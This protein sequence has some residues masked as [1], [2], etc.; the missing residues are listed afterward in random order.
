MPYRVLVANRGEIAIRIA[1]TVREMGL[2]PLGIYTKE[3]VYSLHRRFMFEDREVSSYLDIKDIVDVAVEMGADAVHPGYGFLSENPEFAGEV[4]RKGLVFV[5]PSPQI[6]GMAGDKTAAKV[7]AEKM[8]IPTLPWTEA[9]KLEDVVEFA[10]VHG[11]PVIIKAAGGGGGRGSRVVW[12]EK[13]V[14]TAFEVARKEA[15]RA[16]KD[17]RLF[18]EPYI[19]KAKHIEVQVIGDGSTVVHLFERECSIQRRFQ[20]IVEEAPSPSLNPDERG[21]VHEY[22]VALASGLRYVNAGTVEFVFDVDRREFYFMEINTRIQ[23]EHPVTEMITGIDIVKKQIE[24]ALYG[25]LDLRQSDITRRGHAIEVRIYAEN[26]LTGE[27]SP[28]RITRYV[29]PVG[30]GVRVDTGVTEGSIVTDR[31][32]PLIS[33][34]IVWGP[35]RF[36]ALRRLE[37]ALSE[38][39]IEGVSTNIKQLKLMIASAEFVNASY[40]TAFYEKNEAYLKSKLLDEATLHSVIA[41]ALLEFKDEGC[42]TLLRKTRGLKEILETPRAEKLKR[43]A[44]YYYVVLRGAI[45]RAKQRR[46][47]K[48]P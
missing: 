18:V 39:I 32:D 17:P 28:G 43:S 9:S 40:T 15:E 34:L 35:D 25:V 20:K 4:L 6:I 13:D 38:Y 27:P 26:P 33:K 46:I 1:K 7:Y 36:V 10:R 2:T 24:V 42:K 22:A 23:V 47:V 19:A 44:W 16:F 12:R 29:E 8:G 21:K 3:D 45:E 30:P 41:S 11:Y 31:Y 14:E 37:K 48:K 5:G